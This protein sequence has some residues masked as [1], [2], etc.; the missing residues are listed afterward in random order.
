MKDRYR[1]LISHSSEIVKHMHPEDLD[2]IWTCHECN[3]SFV[4]HSEVDEHKI[5]T[6]HSVIS[7]FDL[8]SGKLLA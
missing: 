4:F 1:L 7:K 2:Y 5:K 8:L 3:S 6:G